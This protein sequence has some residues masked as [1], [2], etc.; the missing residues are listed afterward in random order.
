MMSR[1]PGD[2]LMARDFTVVYQ[3]GNGT[4]RE[5]YVKA[6]SMCHATLTARELLPQC[7]EITRTYHDPN[8]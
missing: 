8:W 1:Y 3:D 2:P 7:V 6:T 5:M 4:R